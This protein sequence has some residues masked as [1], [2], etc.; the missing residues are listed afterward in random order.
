[1]VTLSQPSNGSVFSVGN[2][3][4]LAA[5]AADAD[6]TIAKVEFYRGGTT[7]IGTATSSPYQFVWTNA[8]AGSYSLTAK[9]YDNKN[10]TAVS[11]AVTISIVNNQPPSVTLVTPSGGSFA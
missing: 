6:G 3:I 4:Q 8:T 5:T 9:A 7:L 1:T 11:T 2:A 10:G